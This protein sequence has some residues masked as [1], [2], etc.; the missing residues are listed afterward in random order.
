MTAR[1]RGA[2]QQPQPEPT[3]AEPASPDDDGL[4]LTLYVSGA[5]DLSTRAITHARQLCD[6]DPSHPC[7]LTV[8]D[9]HDDP[10]AV[11]RS[12]V[13]AAPTLVRSKPLPA[14]RVVGDLS[15]T[16]AVLAMLGLRGH[17]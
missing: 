11:M 2:G 8:V 12:H 9:I 13:L 16:D 7:R 14:R 15:H 3:P 1:R 17:R 4:E 10:A 6:S 5:S